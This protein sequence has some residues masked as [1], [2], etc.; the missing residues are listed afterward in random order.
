V[1]AMTIFHARR[2]AYRMSVRFGK[3]LPEA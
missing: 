3:P 2:G 1:V